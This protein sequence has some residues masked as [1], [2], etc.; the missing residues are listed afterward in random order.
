MRK[1]ETFSMIYT[2]GLVVITQCLEPLLE[3]L[4]DKVS[5]G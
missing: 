4:F 5:I 3:T 1:A 2:R